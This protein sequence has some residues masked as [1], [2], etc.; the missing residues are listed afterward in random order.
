MSSDYERPR[1]A[2]GW[3]SVPTMTSIADDDAIG[4]AAE[5]LREVE[6]EA[7]KSAPEPSGGEPLEQLSIDELRK[8]AASFDIPDRGQI[9][10]REKLIAAIRERE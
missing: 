9:I 10:E 1:A 8:I 7:V 5:A 4:S 2:S 3:T 6:V